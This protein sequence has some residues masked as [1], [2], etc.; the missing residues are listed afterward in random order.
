MSRIVRRGLRWFKRGAA[1]GREQVQRFLA[2]HSGPRLTSASSLSSAE[3]LAL[4]D[5]PEVARRLAS[6]DVSAAEAALLSHYAGRVRTDWRAPPP[7]VTDLRLVVDGLSREQLI[8][9]AEAVLEGDVTPHPKKPRRTAAGGIDW[10]H[11]PTPGREWILKIHR[12]AWWVVLGLAYAETGDER[13]AEAIVSQLLDW[14]D[15][16]PP[17]PRKEESSPNWRLM[18]VGLRMRLSWLPVFAL[19]HDSPSFTPKAKLIMLRSICDHARFLFLFKTNRNHLLRESNG[20]ANV[21]AYLPEFKEAACWRETAFLRI[22]HEM[23]EQVNQDGSHIEMSTGYQL[24]VIDE[25]E[26]I[27]DLLQER[28]LSLPHEDLGPWL[29]KMYNVLAKLMLPAG[30]FPQL[31]DGFLLWPHSRLAAAGRKFSRDDFVF[32]GTDGKDGKAAEECSALFPD[33]GLMV[34]RSD[35]TPQARYLLFDA[36]PHGGFHG[37]EDKLSIE[38]GAFGERFIVDP[39]SFT[40]DPT[41]AYR[42]YFVGSQGHNTVMVDGLSQVRFWNPAY[43]TPAVARGN[44]G[45]WAI[46][47]GFDYAAATY[48]EGYGEF[49]PRKPAD[50]QTLCGVRHTRRVLFLKPDYWIVFDDLG[51]SGDHSY[52]WLFHAPGPFSVTERADGGAMLAPGEDRA[53]LAILPCSPDA[54]ELAT[55]CGSEDPIQGWYSTDHHVKHEATA[56]QFSRARGGRAVA[57]YVLYPL[58]PGDSDAVRLESLGVSTPDG[59][60]SEAFGFVVL[61][62]GGK[63]YVVFSDRPGRKNFG[64]WATES[65]VAAVRTD[66]TGEVLGR[67]EQGG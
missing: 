56:L 33:A 16:N 59:A 11:N 48:D 28:G 4:F 54:L 41:E 27:Y 35:W 38:V 51:G 60:A 47:S 40:Y 67:F 45:E 39:G 66:T 17:P 65:A 8:A 6:G 37:H 44:Y 13:Y 50:A 55:F 53:R 52:Q 23:R 58:A 34:M 26:T 36:G 30:G 62:P 5:I 42:K 1:R 2:R 9:R 63:D 61:H 14:V 64:P 18:E 49:N 3:F 22:E 7:E 15:K 32:V 43:R 19:I 57:A 21:G 29:E 10:R 20:L 31:N 12:H 24:L 25:F 46:T